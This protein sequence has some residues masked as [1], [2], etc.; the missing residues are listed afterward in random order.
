MTRILDAKYKKAELVKVTAES[1]HLT[2]KEQSKLLVVL[3]RYENI[4]DGGLGR[5]KTT[6]VKLELKLDAVP[7]HAKLFPIPRS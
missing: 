5:W 7:Y 6:P 2:D 3:R 1:K 4:F